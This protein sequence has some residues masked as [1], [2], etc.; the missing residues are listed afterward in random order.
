VSPAAGGYASSV[1]AGASCRTL[2]DGRWFARVE[3]KPCAADIA[4]HRGFIGALDLATS[5]PIWTSTTFVSPRGRAHALAV[6]EGGM[7][8]LPCLRLLKADTGY[9]EGAPPD[10][11]LS[12]SRPASQCI[13]LAIDSPP[14]ASW[15][16]P[17][18]HALNAPESQ[19]HLVTPESGSAGFR[20]TA[21]PPNQPPARAVER[22][23]AA[24]SFL[25]AP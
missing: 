17:L 8:P 6:L 5:L 9:G 23:I 3:D 10:S 25:R 19:S 16:N 4:D 13:L 21:P 14:Q 2:R 15:G 11:G 22:T 1:G 18:A 12:D 24:I 7:R 20:L